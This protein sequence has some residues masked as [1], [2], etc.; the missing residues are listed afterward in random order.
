MPL[1]S[2]TVLSNVPPPE[3]SKAASS[4][5]R[6]IPAEEL[7]SYASWQP[8]PIGDGSAARA[9][10]GWSVP[11]PP[12]PQATEESWEARIAQARSSG[13]EDGYRDGLSALESFKASH[14]AEVEATHQSRLRRFIEQFEA[15]WSAL[16]P[17]IATSLAETAVALA[18]GVLRAE[19]QLQPQHVVELAREA[20][21]AVAGSARRIELQVHPE[22][23][24]TVHAALGDWLASHGGRLE[25]QVDVGRG[26]CRVRADIADIDARLSTRWT[27]AAALL[28]SRAPW[29]ETPAAR[30]P[31]STA[32]AAAPVA[33]E[34][35]ASPAAAQ[36][37]R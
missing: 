18:R 21:A 10:P 17:A 37:G 26:G 2:R 9:L 8:Q 12:A 24:E 6:I 35:A 3:G 32:G 13:Y 11:P 34:P 33:A 23:R 5:A 7:Q 22:D 36:A 29:D 14:A 27:E 1:R 20:V 16:E 30:T 4:Y 19:L 15:Q 31:D 28:G 25:T